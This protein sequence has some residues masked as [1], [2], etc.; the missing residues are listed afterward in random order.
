L[1]LCAV[2]GLILFSAAAAFIGFIVYDYLMQPG[3][4]GELVSVTIPKGASGHDVG[5]LLAEK[6][7]VENAAFF[8]LAMRLEGSGRPLRQGFYIVPRGLSP[9][10]LLERM[11]EGPKA[12]WD[13]EQIPAELR[14]IIPEGLTIPQAAQLF[15]NPEAFVAAAADPVLVKRLGLNTPTLEGFLMPDTYYFEQKPSER[16]VLK[17]MVEQFEKTY[18]G[19]L[20][21]FPEAAQRD[22]LEVVTIGS[23]IEEEA[24]VAEERP[25]IAAVIHN[26]LAANIPLALDCTLQ[27]ALSKY[28]QRIL[29]QDKTVVSP[30]NTYTRLGL[31]PGPVSSP[32]VASLRA[33]LRP[34]DAKYLYFVSNADGKTHTFSETMAEHN[35]AVARFRREVV[36]QRRAL[37]EQDQ[38][39]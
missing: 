23:L 7:L 18:A 17:R 31:P 21:E 39:Q 20:R 27:Y 15:Q 28:G 35:E 13:P 25:L 1:S 33:A 8:R 4:P 6:G 26:R 9:F 16:E 36:I 22:K 11:Y 19:L 29:D 14:A 2:V 3:T 37:R 5:K 12:P 10:E 32:G 24:R 34:A 38:P 30:Y